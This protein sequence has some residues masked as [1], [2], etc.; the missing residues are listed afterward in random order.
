[1]KVKFTRILMI[2]TLTCLLVSYGCKKDPIEEPMF[3]LSVNSVEII[4]ENTS[5]VEINGNSTYSVSSNN[6]DIAVASIQ[7]KTITITAKKHTGTADIKVIDTKDPSRIA[8]IKVTVKEDPMFSLSTNSAEITIEESFDVEITGKSTYSV[9]SS[10]SDIA[11][12]SITDQT[13]IIKAKEKEGT[14]V[15]KV[16]DTK[17][18]SLTAEIQVKVIPNPMFTL[19]TDSAEI[20]AGNSLT[21]EITG[22]SSYSVSSANEDIAEASI[23]DK[24]ITITTKENIGTTTIKVTDT[25]TPS[26]TMDIAISV[27]ENIPEGVVIQDGVLISWD[28]SKLPKNGHID[29]PKSVTKIGAK[30]FKSCIDL[31]SVSMGDNVTSI[32]DEAFALCGSLNNIKLSS[33]ITHIGNGAFKEC[34]RIPEIDFPDKLVTI[35]DLAFEFCES[36]TSITLPNTVT[37]I[38]ERAF[39]SA[40]ISKIIIPSSVNKI[41]DGIFSNCA[42]LTAID[43]DNASTSF[44]SENGVLFNKDK[45]KLIQYPKGK[46]DYSYTI[47]A[48]VTSIGKEAFY[49]CQNLSEIIIPDGVTRI[50]DRTFV[51]TFISSVKIP[52]AVTYIGEHAFAQTQL[53]S[54]TLP[55]N[56]EEIGKSAF[57]NNSSLA[58]LVLN[59][60]LTEIPDFAFHDCEALTTLKMGKNI[61][62]IGK[63]AF[64]HCNYVEDLVL[65][66]SLVFIDELAFS[67]C[68]FSKRIHIPAS[69]KTIKERA[70]A[71]IWDAT[72]VTCDAVNP[73]QL[74]ADVFV[75]IAEGREVKLHVPKGSKSAYESADQWK[76]FVIVEEE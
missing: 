32:G 1:M 71:E 35:G 12:A 15:I 53:T 34:L 22:K 63:S 57:A 68:H 5:K 21:V 7:G 52:D 55:A 38:G 51:G 24:T 39:A 70:F 59:D 54:L 74:G 67:D 25:K 60:K 49:Y 9:S 65:S 26:Q 30:V 75:N 48:S 20:L 4:A 33:N 28:C 14:A 50:E 56:V 16:T 62:R 19:S 10:N 27:I 3:T 46:S 73:P 23:K 13:I 18:A 37:E 2:C 43:V 31:I 76:N 44:V 72:D 69:V 47:P 6:N 42:N 45:T 29:I 8:E 64:Y 11:T 61:T 58:D 17:D 41:G 40:P 66:E 36:I